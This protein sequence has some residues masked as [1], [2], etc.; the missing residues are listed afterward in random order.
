[1]QINPVEKPRCVQSGLLLSNH[2]LTVSFRKIQI[3]SLSSGQKA[4]A[5]E[6]TERLERPRIGHFEAGRTQVGRGDFP[7]LLG[8]L[9]TSSDWEVAP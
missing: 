8:M 5:A 9:C 1:M 3:C 2:S 4:A 6:N 7:V